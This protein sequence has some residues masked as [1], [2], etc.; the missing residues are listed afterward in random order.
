MNARRSRLGL[1]CVLAL[2]VCVAIAMSAGAAEAKKKKKSGHSITVSK[3]TAT[4]IPA[5]DGTNEI[6]GVATVPFTVGK[7]AK[8]KVVSPGSLTS[9]FQI[10]DPA[11]FLDDLDLKIVAPNGRT[12]FL[13]NPAQFFGLGDTVPVVGPLTETPNS[14]TGYCFPDPSPPPPGCPFGSP[15]NTLAP[16]WAGTAGNVDL[17]FFSGVPARGTWVFKALN[18]STTSTHVLNSASIHMKLVAAPK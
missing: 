2:A 14:S 9:T 10:S 13:D 16:P 8:G 18:F 7:K 1:I 17:A 4:A 3:T 11:G 12:V 15:D 5:G 6:A